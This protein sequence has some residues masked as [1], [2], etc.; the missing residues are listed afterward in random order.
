MDNRKIDIHSEGETD[1]I[2]AMQLA[3]K[4]GHTQTIGYSLELDG[5]VMVLYWAKSEKMTPF[6]YEMSRS[7]ITAFVW[8]WLQ[9]MK[10]LGDAPDHDGDNGHGFRVYNEAWGH[11]MNRWEA[12][13]A[14]TPIWA[15]Y[16]K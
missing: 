12:F 3:T 7:E 10:P 13:I 4:Q 8:G 11:I 5:S 15:M 9:K 14:I 16:G 1:F 2:T 6:P